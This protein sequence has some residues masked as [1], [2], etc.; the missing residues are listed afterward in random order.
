MSL[1]LHQEMLKINKII[2]RVKMYRTHPPL[3]KH[4]CQPHFVNTTIYCF[5][6]V[7]FK[8]LHLTQLEYFYLFCCVTCFKC[9][10]SVFFHSVWLVNTAC[11]VTHLSPT[12]Q[13]AK[14]TAPECSCQI[15]ATEKLRELLA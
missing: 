7:S 5:T 11:K 9:L 1:H 6:V 3:Q 8:S 4:P 10:Q 15:S 2:L 12:Q 14:V 13:D